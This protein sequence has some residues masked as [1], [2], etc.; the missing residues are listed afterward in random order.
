M[1]EEEG[2]VQ[3]LK[4]KASPGLRGWKEEDT[5]HSVG[6]H[7]TRQGSGL[8]AQGDMAPG[9]RTFERNQKTKTKLKNKA[10]LKGKGQRWLPLLQEYQ[11][12]KEA[13]PRH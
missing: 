13:F 1:V 9:T 6:E 3:G 10:S 7:L 2:K 11:R 4:S 5:S 8:K 12:L